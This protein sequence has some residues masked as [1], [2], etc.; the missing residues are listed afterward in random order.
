LGA[1]TGAG[2]PLHHMYLQATTMTFLGIVARQL[3]T[4]LAVRT[5]TAS[6]RAIGITN[7]PLLLWG[8]A[9][10]VTFSLALVYIGP[11]AS[12]FAVAVP[13]PAQLA[14]LMAY[15]PIVWGIDELRKAHQ[16][17]AARQTDFERA[18]EST[19]P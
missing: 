6:L 2:S 17:R 5:D 11:L 4:G 3:G 1:D 10:E 13:T 8:M 7:N 12:I 15:P 19:V 18:P 16:R 9:F 14:A